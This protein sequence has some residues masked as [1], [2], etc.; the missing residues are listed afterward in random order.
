MRGAERGFTLVEI[1]VVLVI[2]GILGTFLFGKIFESGERAKQRMNDLKMNAL[3]QK[4]GEYRLMYNGLPN[5]LDGLTKCTEETG[6]G[7][8]PLLDSDDDALED[9]W[10]SRFQYST[11]GNGRSFAITSLGADGQPG[12]EGVNYDFT[13]KGP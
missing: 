2:L 6:P 11:D 12:G 9:A 10:G 13:V 7:C 1:L 4:L 3:K 8:V 5:S